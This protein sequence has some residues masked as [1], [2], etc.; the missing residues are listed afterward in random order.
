M[1]AP[2]AERSEVLPARGA[3]AGVNEGLALVLKIKF[4]GSVF[5]TGGATPRPYAIALSNRTAFVSAVTTDA[6]NNIYA[7][8]GFFYHNVFSDG[9]NS[10][11]LEGVSNRPYGFAVS[12]VATSTTFRWVGPFVKSSTTDPSNTSTLASLEIS[13]IVATNTGRVIIGGIIN[14]TIDVDPSTA[15]H[16][17]AGGP[18]G[19]TLNAATGAFVNAQTAAFTSARTS[20]DIVWNAFV[21]VAPKPTGAPYRFY[22]G[23]TFEGQLPFSSRRLDSNGATDIFLA[24]FPVN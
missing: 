1:F 23:G 5:M 13:S 16:L 6:S 17:T 15:S 20:H 2:P 21:V 4:D 7:A 18:L 11:T 9:T 24:Q 22:L 12:L 10:R 3:G 8:G 19:L 14:A